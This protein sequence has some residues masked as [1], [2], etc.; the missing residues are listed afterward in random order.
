[1]TAAVSDLRLRETE[2][3]ERRV[4]ERLEVHDAS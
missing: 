3:H 4:R 2:N 1:M